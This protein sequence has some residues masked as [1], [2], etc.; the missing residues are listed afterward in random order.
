MHGLKVEVAGYKNQVK[1]EY[2]SLVLHNTPEELHP[3]Q[4]KRK[5]R[6]TKPICSCISPRLF[7]SF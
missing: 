4:K 7:L 6:E 5:R 3:P 2:G 1:R